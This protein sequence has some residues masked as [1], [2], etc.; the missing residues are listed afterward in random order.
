VDA[1]N[2]YIEYY[3]IA[4][5]TRPITRIIYRILYKEK[6]VVSD[7]GRQKTEPLLKLERRKS[8]ISQDEVTTKSGFGRR[9]AG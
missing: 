9:S 6:W 3:I 1:L 2:I 8:G 7:E 4:A 5:F